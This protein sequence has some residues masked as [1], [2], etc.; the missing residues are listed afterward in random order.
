[1]FNNKKPG[2][3]KNVLQKTVSILIC[4]ALALLY[5]YVKT[6]KTDKK[7]VYDRKPKEVNILKESYSYASERDKELAEEFKI[8]FIKECKKLEKKTPIRV[9][10]SFI[11]KKIDITDK[12]ITYSYQFKFNKSEISEEEWKDFIELSKKEIKREMLSNAKESLPKVKI[13][14]SRILELADISL[15]YIYNDINGSIVGTIHLDY[16]DF[17]G[18]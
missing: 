17:Y 3:M 8:G 10:D 6:D 13:S 2:I 15:E 5:T 9:D 12:L 18:M 16:M 14:L 1:M 11:L 4:S 7:E